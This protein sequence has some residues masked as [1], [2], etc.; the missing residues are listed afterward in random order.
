MITA[1]LSTHPQRPSSQRPVNCATAFVRRFV[2]ANG[3]STPDAL[4]EALA[5][6]L[7]ERALTAG[8][9]AADIGI[10]GPGL[11]RGEAQ[12]ALRHIGLGKENL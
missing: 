7:F 4:I 8:A 2:A 10:S 11:F 1:M 3:S 9:W 12:V 6:H 5:Q